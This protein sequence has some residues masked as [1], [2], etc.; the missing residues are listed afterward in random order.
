MR[1]DIIARAEFLLTEVRLTPEAAQLR[2]KDYFPELE[3]EER[4]RFVHEAAELVA[5]TLRRLN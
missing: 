5:E 4:V 1:E 3:L 2:L